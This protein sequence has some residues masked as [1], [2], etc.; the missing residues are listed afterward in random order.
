M[1]SIWLEISAKCVSLV[2]VRSKSV[3][4]LI[5]FEFCNESKVVESIDKFLTNLSMVT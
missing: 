5:A 3:R 1:L 2:L 4:T